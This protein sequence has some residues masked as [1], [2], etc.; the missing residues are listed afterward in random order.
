[1][2]NKH[3]FS[4]RFTESTGP[5]RLTCGFLV[6]VSVALLPLQDTWQFR[7][8]LGWSAGVL[9]YLM[10]AWWLCAHSNA[11]Q[12]RKQAQSQDEPSLVILLV[13][14]LATSVCVI[15]IAEL[16]QQSQDLTGLQRLLRMGVGLVALGLSWLFIQTL[17]SFHYAHRYYAQD[18]RVQQTRSNLERDDA[19]AGA[20]QSA[21]QALQFPH[22]IDP[23][24]FD[25]LYYAHVVGMTSQ[26]SDVVTISRELRWLTLMHS[27]LS[28]AFNMLVVAFSINVVVG[29]LR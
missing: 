28:F 8:L 9:V 21:R 12:T 11:E 16:M 29:A 17:F 22:G 25:F 1:M 23:D 27:V 26:V 15:A 7:G 14:L 2:R 13:L 5:Q 4:W 18:K 3:L 24:Y 6:G 20:G 19:K 10:L